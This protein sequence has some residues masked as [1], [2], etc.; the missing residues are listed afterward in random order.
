MAEIPFPDGLQGVNALPK[1]K[2]VLTNCYRNRKGELLG[3]RG[4]DQL[5]TTG[6][7]AR[8][9]FEWDENL[10]QVVSSSLIKITDLTTGAFVTIGTIAGSATIQTAIGFNDAVIIVKNGALYTLGKE[11]DTTA[12]SSVG[13]AFGG[14]ARFNHGGSAVG[15][16]ST[17]TIINFAANP[18]YNVENTSV[19]SVEP[20]IFS[21]GI[22]SVTDNGGIAVFNHS[23][24][25]PQLGQE[26]TISGYIT[27]TAY[28]TTGTVTAR[29]AS[30]FE[31]SAIAFGTDEAVGSYVG[32]AS[33]TISSITF[34]TSETVG[35]FA[36]ILTNILGNANFRTCVSVTHKDNRF[37]YC[38]ADGSPVFFSD[39]G[40]AGS[41]QVASF[42]DAEQLPDENN[43]V[44]TLKNILFIT[45]T[46]SIEQFQNRG[47]T[48]V[49]FVR[50]D[51]GAI[52]AGFIGG[53]LEYR[54]TF[55]FVGRDKNQDFGIYS[56]GSG[57][58]PKISNKAIDTILGTYTINELSEAVASRVKWEGDDI[59]TFTFR[60]DSFGFFNGEWFRLDTLINGTSRPWRAGFIT[61]FAGDYYTAFENK[62]GI[63]QDLNTDYGERTI[64]VIQFGIKQPN[65][66]WFRVQSVT[67]GISQGFND[68]DTSS[69]VAIQIS[70]DNRLFSEPFFRNLSAIG[71]YASKL[72]WNYPGGIGNFEGFMAIRIS[73]AEDVKFSSDHLIV[74]AK[75]ALELA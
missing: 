52:D 70:L 18:L 13:S 46:D 58:A 6:K 29:T 24:T 65:D 73:T 7:V 1:T 34:G 2:R 41:V 3:R 25:S 51:A 61:E 49:P 16:I 12:I 28:N 57:I 59:A 20:E 17:V 47:T 48:P 53:A 19:S 26:V 44:W 35:F 27:N 4:I 10:Y 22:S 36:S 32:Q 31:I 74:D 14:V 33:F 23:G 62:I 43:Q 67:L 72:V 68:I 11:T 71:N 39:V 30:N 45:G 42:F 75:G 37:I 9:Q 55:L 5:N 54:N 64:R 63:F 66:D 40:D 60:R 21:T 8:G 15:G 50:S 38:P 69:G 56:I